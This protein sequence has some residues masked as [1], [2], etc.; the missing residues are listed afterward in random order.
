MPHP[1]QSPQPLMRL[2]AE[3]VASFV[4]SGENNRRAGAFLFRFA[5]KMSSQACGTQS[6]P[7][8][9]IE[10]AHQLFRN[11]LRKKMAGRKRLTACLIRALSPSLQNVIHAVERPFL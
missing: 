10:F 6:S 1:T 11:L 7:Q 5:R 3:P 9:R 8:E 2:A 4:N